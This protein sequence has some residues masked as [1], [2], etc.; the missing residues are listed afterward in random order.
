MKKATET[1]VSKTAIMG[2]FGSSTPI[3]L[4]T[5]FLEMY[6]S[7]NLSSSM[8]SAE[9]NILSGASYSPEFMFPPFSCTRMI[10]TTGLLAICEG[11]VQGHARCYS[12][13]K[14]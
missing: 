6:L 3:N 9:S 13:Q 12:I 8:Q 5:P 2:S 10:D 11:E 14:Y 7:V 4:A 1:Q